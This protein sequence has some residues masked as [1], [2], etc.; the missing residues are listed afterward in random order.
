MNGKVGE[1]RNS[2]LVSTFGPGAIM[3]LPDFSV[4]ISSTDH[5][6]LKLCEVIKEPRLQR[7]LN[8]SRIYAPPSLQWEQ[9]SKQGT[10]PAYRFPR[11]MVCPKC[12]K[13]SQFKEF[14]LDPDSQ[15]AYCHCEENTKVFPA[16][17]LVACPRG[18]IDDFPWSFYVHSKKGNFDCEGSLFLNDKG[19]SGSIADVEVECKSCEEK[20]TLED[21]FMGVGLPSCR[22][23]K[24]WIGPWSKEECT[25]KSR[26]L[27]RGA[28]NLYFP[29]VQSALSIPPYTSTIH[30]DV[31][32]E[33]DRLGKVDSKEKLKMYIEDDLFP[34]FKEFDLD[35][36]WGTILQQRGLGSGEEQDLY[37]PEWEALLRGGEADTE[38]EFETEEQQVPD[39]FSKRIGRLIMVR[40]L[41]EVRVLDGFSRI[42]PLPDITSVGEED[43]TVKESFKAS[44]SESRKNWRP[45]IVTRGEGIFITLHEDA[46]SAWE[47]EKFSDSNSIPMAKEFERYCKDRNMENTVE[48]PGTRYVLLHTLS[49]A[50]M[51]QLCFSSGYSSTSLRERIYSRKKDGQ[52]MA[53]VLIYTATPD[54]EGSLGGLVEL[55]KTDRFEEILFHALEDAKFCSGD[56]LCSEHKPDAIGDLNG[57]A[58]HACQLA[59]ETSCEKS[60]RF[61]D[62]GFIVPTVSDQSLA[63]FNQE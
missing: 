12:R 31:A 55:G 43:D 41:T 28:S 23:H 16:R 63:F 54:S 44:I 56:P 21:A 62:R 14:M 49:H 52:N 33:M 11:F 25:E 30:Q 13:L 47:K 60:N 22:G 2:Q 4:I 1:V 42:E 53:G 10:L 38:Y 26:A 45:G 7:K 39:R 48:F 51:R 15:I 24:Q 37:Y 61:L 18:H 50:L 27:L 9:D 58:C 5:W 40:R 36:I 34:T 17:F 8:I 46:L 59:A 6:N 29:V 32:E 20:R 19:V 35:E 57:A 3:D